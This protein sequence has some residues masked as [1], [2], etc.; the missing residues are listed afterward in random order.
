[1]ASLDVLDIVPTKAMLLKS[2]DHTEFKATVFKSHK[3]K[4]KT[5]TFLDQRNPSE[6]NENEFNLK[7]A[8]HEVFNFGVSGLESKDKEAAKIALAIRLGAK[9]PKNEHKNYKELIAGNKKARDQSIEN[10]A[11]LQLGKNAQGRASVTHKKL[12]SARRKK[13]LDG[14]ITQHYG[15]VNPKIFK[16]KSK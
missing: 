3:S 7:K 6:S 15:V 11:L 4:T 2:A 1:M 10:A 5:N 13:K 16:K 8:K 9:P 14:Q 12:N